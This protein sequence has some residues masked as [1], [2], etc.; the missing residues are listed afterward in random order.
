MGLVLSIGV[1]CIGI[2]LF[3][4]NH[5]NETI[6]YRVFKG[7]PEEFTSISNIITHEFDYSGY[8]VMQFGALL[9]IATP[10]ARV[11][12]SLISFYLSKDY[13]YTLI[14]AFVFGMLIYSFF[15]LPT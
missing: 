7:E 9:M 6:D 11:A 14:T 10:I 5:G 15:G 4:F 8:C 12:F 1:I 3:L 13:Q 2:S